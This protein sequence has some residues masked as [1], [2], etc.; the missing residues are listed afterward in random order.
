MPVTVPPVPTPQ[1]I[2]SSAPPVSRQISSAVVRRWIAGFAGL[3]NCCSITAPSVS[4]TS[5]PAR[6][7]APGIPSA[8]GVSS[9]SAP[10]SASRRRRSI[11]MLSGMVRISR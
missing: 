10:S 11:D 8:A 7:R 5:C 2:A 6:A 1:T 4:A 3:A 9:S